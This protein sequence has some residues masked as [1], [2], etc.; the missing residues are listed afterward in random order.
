MNIPAQSFSALKP[1][2]SDVRVDIFT[3]LQ[4]ANLIPNSELRDSQCKSTQIEKRS[5]IPH[6][7][8]YKTHVF[9]ISSFEKLT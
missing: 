7:F 8:Q 9:H 6:C 2:H 1:P 3:R 4:A 5:Y